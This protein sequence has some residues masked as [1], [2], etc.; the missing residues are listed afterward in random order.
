VGDSF[1]LL[2][3]ASRSGIFTSLSLP[4]A[5]QWQTNYGATSFTLSVVGLNA[6]GPAAVKLTPISYAA[7]HFTLQI[8]GVLGPDYVIFAS[9]NLSSWSAISTSTPSFMPFT[10]VD[11]NAGA[12]PRRFYRALLA[13]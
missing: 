9:T 11:T 4:S 5:A 7:G 10:F 6:S 13:P 1:T 2:S 8:T 3:Y 12:F